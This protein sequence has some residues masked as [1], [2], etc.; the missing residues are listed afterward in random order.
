MST[1]GIRHFLDLIDVPASE[2]RGI[3]AASR[4]MKG[5]RTGAAKPLAGSLWPVVPSVLK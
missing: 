1:D 2:L 3:I 5:G 4:A